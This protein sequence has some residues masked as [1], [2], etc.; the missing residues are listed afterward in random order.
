MAAMPDALDLDALTAE[1]VQYLDPGVLGATDAVLALRMD[2][3]TIFV[4]VA[5]GEVRTSRTSDRRADATL[6][7][8]FDDVVAL[9]SGELDGAIAYLQGRI[10][11]EGDERLAIGLATAFRRPGDGAAALDTGALDAGEIARVVRDTERGQLERALSGAARG[12]VLAEIFRRFPAHV[13]EDRIAGS[14]AVIGW[15]ITAAGGEAARHRVAFAGGRV[16][17]D[18]DVPADAPPRVTIIC[19]GVTLLELVTGN[20]NP[21]LA[22]LTRRLRIK[23]DLGF[24]A[25]LP[26]FF[27]IP[28]A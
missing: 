9:L 1:L 14:D 26:T 25:Q 15:K 19:D 13:R 28:H 21:A 24:A 2:A 20:A 3:D 8:G 10:G 5:G 4:R 16:L 7:A 6:V 12:V 17:V 18:D 27:R 23:G 22:F 11:L